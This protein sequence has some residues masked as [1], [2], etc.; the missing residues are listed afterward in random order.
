MSAEKM[1]ARQEIYTALEKSAQA[2][3]TRAFVLVRALDGIHFYAHEYH[4]D[5]FI[6]RRLCARVSECGVLTVTRESTGQVIAR[7]LPARGEVL[8][9]S[10]IEE[11][12]KRLG[13]SRLPKESV[14]LAERELERAFYMVKAKTGGTIYK[15]QYCNLVASISIRGVLTVATENTG[16]ILARSLPA[17]PEVVDPRF[18]RDEV[19]RILDSWDIDD[20]A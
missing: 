15:R 1:T 18:I 10:F 8:D 19:A 9:P 17:C 13:V 16:Q 14:W 2:E 6:N 3:L 12:E 20:E 4:G 11:E 7:S 5:D